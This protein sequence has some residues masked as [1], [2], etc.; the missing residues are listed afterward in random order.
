MTA[1]TPKAEGPDFDYTAHSDD[2]FSFLEQYRETCP[3]L[4]GDRYGGYWLLYNYD[5]VTAA[6]RDTSTY[7]SSKGVTI[8]SFKTP[9]P[10]MPV[11]ADPPVHEQYRRTLQSHFTQPAVEKLEAQIR[12]V[13]IDRIESFAALGTADLMEVLAGPVPPTIIG[14]LLGLEEKLWNDIRQMTQDLFHAAKVE[15]VPAQIAVN[16]RMSAMFTEQLQER[17]DRP[18]EDLLT[19]IIHSQV[20][21]EQIPFDVSYGM[22]QLIVIAGHETTVYGIGSIINH[23]LD[24]PD[25]RTRGLADPVYLER[26]IHESLRIESPIFA[27]GRNLTK[28]ACP[29]G[30]TIEAGDWAYL[31]F[32]AAN[33]DAKV[34]ENP[35]EFEPERENVQK[36]IAFGFGRHRCLGEFLARL[37]MKVSFEEIYRR[38]PNLR[39]SG[40]QLPAINA[41]PTRGPITLQVSWGE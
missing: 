20:N 4:H 3:V 6:A 9:F 39:R 19:T 24:R 15:D 13:V 40:P 16:Q 27:M 8:P 34:F 17:I 31:S 28:D 25:V 2:M 14:M 10:S 29:H 12:Q 36:Q 23:T 5:D 11:E 41:G 30:T 35:E 1:V 7:S 21:G 22:L 32:S 38:L 33:H 18:R 37:E 26:V